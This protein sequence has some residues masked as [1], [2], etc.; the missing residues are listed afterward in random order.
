LG[1]SGGSVDSRIVIQQLNSRQRRILI[2]K[3]I[4]GRYLFIGSLLFANNEGGISIIPFDLHKLKIKG[5]P[6]AVLS[7][8]NT[9]TWSGAAFISVSETGNLIFLPRSNKPLNVLDVV[10]RSGNLIDKDSIPMAS[11]ERMGYGWHRISIS[12]SGKQIGITGRSFGSTD[13][14]LL[15]LN[16]GDTER[17]TFNPAVDESPIYSPNGNSFAYASA[18]TGTNRRLFI[19]DLD[20]S[21]NPHL[22]KTWPRHIHFTSWSPDGKLLA[23]Y[24]YTST[25]GTDCYAISVDKDEYISVATSEANES[26]AQFSPDGRWLAYQSDESGRYEIYVVSFPSLQG[27]RQI[28]EDGGRVPRWDRSGKFIYYI[29]NGFM[30]AQPVEIS[31]ELAR[32]KPVKLFQTNA[33]EFVLSPDGQKFYLVRRNIK[34]PNPPLYLITNWFQELK[35]KTDK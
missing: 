20:S 23:A 6:Q 19:E 8:V 34:R 33:S 22:F 25:N 28:S 17:K 3:A 31:H 29:S 11:I 1:P 10:D 24:D 4:F 13:V 12:P 16:T 27:K 5:E 7:N 32:A 15:S 35:K 18:L 14:W 26:D 2:D 21:G 30:I 9:A